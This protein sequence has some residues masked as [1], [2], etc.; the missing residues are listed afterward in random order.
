MF[1]SLCPSF[2]HINK[3][4]ETCC[5]QNHVE[6]GLHLQSYK[7]VMAVFDPNSVI[8]INT[9]Q[10]VKSILCDKLE[11]PDEFKVQW[12]KNQSEDCGDLRKFSLQIENIIESTLG[13]W[14]R[15]EYETY[16]N[17]IGDESKKNCIEGE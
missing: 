17:K 15:H 14:M 6:F 11:D 16:Q 12:I 8:P 10:F 7:Q 5:C 1:E 9:T 13:S 2:V 3:I 4:R